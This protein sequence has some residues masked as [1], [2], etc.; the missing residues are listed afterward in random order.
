MQLSN[1]IVLYLSWEKSWHFA[2]PT[3]VSPQNDIRGMSAENFTL[4]P[5][6]Y[7]SVLCFWSV[8]ANP[9]CGKTNQK[10]YLELRSD[11]SS[12]SNFYTHSSNVNSHTNFWLFSQAILYLGQKRPSNPNG[13]LAKIVWT[14]VCHTMKG[15]FVPHDTMDAGTK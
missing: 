1:N 11:K 5:W 7:R 13:L 14:T 4:M 12:V 6:H 8:D 3:L 2:M 9:S 10:H 15:N